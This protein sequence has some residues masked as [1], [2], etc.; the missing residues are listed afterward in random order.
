MFRVPAAAP[1][2]AASCVNVIN[3]D[4]ATLQPVPDPNTCL[5]LRGNLGRNTLIG[6]GLVNLDFSVFKNNHIKRISDS[7]NVQFRAEF[8]NIIN[9]TN[10]SP[11][12]DKRNVFDSTGHPVGDAA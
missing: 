5:N 6:P 1:G 9:H 2:I 10:F 11:P 12:L 4:P 7:F 3:T 8:F